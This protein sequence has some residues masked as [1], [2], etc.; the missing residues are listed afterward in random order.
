MI[1]TCTTCGKDLE[2][3]KINNKTLPHNCKKCRLIADRVR[4]KRCMEKRRKEL[5]L[6][7]IR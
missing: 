3:P 5:S 2:K 4:Y 7:E 6:H 1:T